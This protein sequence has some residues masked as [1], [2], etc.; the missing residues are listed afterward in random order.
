MTM[1]AQPMSTSGEEPAPNELI[2]LSRLE[3][4][5]NTIRLRIAALAPD[6]LF[7]G[8]VDQLSIAEEIGLAVDRERA[9]LDAFRRAQT[10]SRPQ[11][12]EPQPGPALLDRE[13]HEDLAMLFDLRRGTLDLLRTINDE[14][15]SQLVSMPGGG[16]AT[17]RELAIRLAQQDVRMLRTISEQRRVFLRTSGVDEL[18]DAGVAGKLGPNIGQ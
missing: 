11:L 2:A 6:Q 15:W 3:A 8:T 4:T 18:R 14:G 7:R 16:T 5:C 13:F 17:L 9:Y 10:E 1:F 12:I